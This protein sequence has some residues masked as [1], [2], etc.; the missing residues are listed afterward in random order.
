MNTPLL[1]QIHDPEDLKTLQKE[2]LIPLCEEIR[3][4]LLESVSHTGG[5]LASNLGAIELTVALHRAMN[6]PMDK[7]I[8]DVGHQCYTHKLLTGRKEAFGGLRQLNGLSGFPNP[9]ES[10]HDSFIAG[11][12]NTAI[13]LA[14]GMAQA[15]KIKGEPGKVIAVVGDGAFTGGMVYEGLNNISS[16]DNLIIILNDNKMSI[17]KNVG[18]MARYLTSLRTDPNYFRTKV[19]MQSFLDSIP[20]VGTPVRKGL[21][22]MKQTVRRSIYKSTMFEEMGFLY[23]GPVDG[24]DVCQM[25]ELLQNLQSQLL[26]QPLFI[27]AVTVKGKGYDPAERNSGQFHGV[28]AFALDDPDLTPP[29]P[30]KSFSGIFG[31][32]LTELGKKDTRIC[33]VTAAMKYGTGLQDFAHAYRA[34]FFDVGMAEQHAVTFAAGLASSGFLPVVAIYS[35]FLQ[36]SYDQIIH[37]VNLLKEPVLFAVDRAGLVPG[38]GETHQGIYD[39]AFFSQIGIPTWSPANYEELRVC[40]RNCLAHATG[41]QAIRYPRGSQSPRLEAL[42]CDGE[43]YRKV[44]EKAEETLAANEAGTPGYREDGGRQAGEKKT[45]LVSYGSETEDVLDGAR[46]LARQG[47]GCDCYKLLQIYPIPEGLIPTLQKYDV[48]LFAEEGIGRGGIGE[49]LAFALQ[50]SGWK[51]QYLYAGVD[52]EKLTHATVPEL[53]KRMGLDGESLAEMVLAAGKPENEE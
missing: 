41:P 50:R 9:R 17:S 27:H 13:S 32:E 36:R 31:Q 25:T 14:I 24:N 44:A 29:S 18:A 4:F 6:S 35:T 34:R 52:N 39:P 28:S 19:N 45:A 8:F 1:D 10:I 51:G 40:L 20:V 38:D 53:K 37:D 49:H 7:I 26:I 12:G 47:I 42:G 33:A 48:I 43:P 22:H 30:S 11:H 2:E 46:L 16:L 21:Q 3:S 23:V 5:H 15:K